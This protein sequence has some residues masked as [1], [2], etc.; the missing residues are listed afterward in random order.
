R[1]IE[2]PSGTEGIEAP[3]APPLTDRPELGSEPD[4]AAFSPAALRILGARPSREQDE[5]DMPP[6]RYLVALGD[7]R[8]EVVLA[9]APA[10]SRGSRARAGKTW[11][12]AAPYLVWAPLPYDTPD[13]GLAFACVGAGDEGCLFLDLA[14]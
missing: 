8:I 14:A 1:F 13:D 11:L 4:E 5:D 12:A 7:D 3:G 10:A 2:A 9:E 6:Q